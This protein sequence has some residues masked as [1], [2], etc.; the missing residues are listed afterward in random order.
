[1][2]KTC[3]VCKTKL[4]ASI[5]KPSSYRDEFCDEWVI[6]TTRRIVDIDVMYSNKEI[7]EDV[8]CPNCGIKYKF[9]NKGE[10]GEVTELKKERN[11]TE[12]ST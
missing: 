8:W 3:A 11:D 4:R 6:T 10:T 2:N 5:A 9:F 12:I 7:I 1:M